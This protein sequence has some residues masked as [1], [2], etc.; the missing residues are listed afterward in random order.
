MVNITRTENLL[1]LAPHKSTKTECIYNLNKLFK[2]LINIRIAS[3]TD[4]PDCCKTLQI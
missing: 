3:L 1:E 2:K 4:L